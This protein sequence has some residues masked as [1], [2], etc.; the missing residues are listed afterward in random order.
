MLV[1]VWID[2]DFG[3]DPESN[4]CDFHCVSECPVGQ[5]SRIIEY[6]DRGSFRKCIPESELDD[7]NMLI[8]SSPEDGPAQFEIQVPKIKR[9]KYLKDERQYTLI[10]DFDSTNPGIFGESRLAYF[11]LQHPVVL[12]IKFQLL[13]NNRKRTLRDISRTTRW[14]S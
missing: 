12:T 1:L 9:H 4:P 10:S 6:E 11:I 3:F 14:Q 8:C 7:E 2:F 13:A 5:V